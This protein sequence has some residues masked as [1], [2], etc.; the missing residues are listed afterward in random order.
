M[1]EDT[2]VGILAIL[3]GTGGISIATAIISYRLKSKEGKAASNEKLLDTAIKRIETQDLLIKDLYDRSALSVT[4]QQTL[5][6]NL[7]KAN[8]EIEILKRSVSGKDNDG[9]GQG[10]ATS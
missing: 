10:N 3:F 4:Q 6:E 9:P 5:Q 8:A 7:A 2:L 1:S